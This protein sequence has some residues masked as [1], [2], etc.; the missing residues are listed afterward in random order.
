MPTEAGDLDDASSHA[1]TKTPLKVRQLTKDVFHV[2][3]DISNWECGTNCTP[4]AHEPEQVL[5]SVEG[6][7]LICETA[8][9]IL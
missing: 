5:S 2:G 7:T 4:R 9:P 1:V 3:S 6:R 8:W